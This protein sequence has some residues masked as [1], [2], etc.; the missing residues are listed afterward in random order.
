MEKEE[1]LEI[2]RQGT[3]KPLTVEELVR[4]LKIDDIPVFLQLIRELELAGEIILT[5]KQKYGLPERMGLLSGRLQGNV[6][7]FAFLL[8][9]TQGHP[10]VYIGQEELN[11][12]LH[13]DRVVVRL[14]PSG[15]RGMRPEGEVIRILARANQTVVGTFDKCKKYGFLIPDDKRLSIDIFIPNEGMA[16]AQHG[17]KVVVE[18]IRW[19]EGR[20][21]PEGKIIEILGQSDQPG[22]DVLAIVRKYGLPEVFPEEV[23]Q[24]AENLPKIVLPAEM[25]GR[26]DFRGVKTV[27]IDGADAKDLDDAI[28]IEALPGGGWR[29]M[30]HIAD[31]AY[32]VPEGT[33]ID[34]EAF[35]RGNSV[36]L[37][38]RV[39]PMLPPKLS[40]G[41]CS[42]NAGEDRL[43]MTAII[44]LDGGAKIVAHEVTPSVINVDQRMT[45][46][47]V[48]QILGNEDLGLVEQYRDFVPEF[49][50]MA[51]LAEKLFERRMKRGAIDFN[52]PEFKVILD[53]QGKPIE[54]KKHYRT[55]AESIIEEFMLLVNETIAEYMYWLEAPFIYRV[56][57]DPDLDNVAE[58]N[59]FLHNLGYH[60]KVTDGEVT[61]Q[62][63]QDVINKVLGEPEEKVVNTVVLR[64]M[65]HA[66]YSPDSLGHFGLAAQYYAH[67]TAPI[68]RYA[69]LVIHRIIRE[70]LIGEPTEKRII[71]LKRQMPAWAEQASIREKAA[72]EA[73]RESVDLKMVEYMKRHLGEVFSGTISGV[74]SFGLFVE[75]DNGVEGLVHIST[76]ADDY[77]IFQEKQLALLGQ[78]TR[79]SYRLGGQ[80][81]V[82]VVKVNVEER[83]IDFELKDDEPQTKPII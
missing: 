62:S 25:E 70:Y 57:E 2:M 34:E 76:I 81:T 8:P 39:I 49:K 78:H 65:R 80:V 48:R 59:D 22:V 28:S 72:E 67:F 64:S 77:Y 74:T 56:H 51:E 42:L 30:V 66:R 58:L 83:Q 10:D 16:D 7:G 45:Y 19:Q 47:G 63:F 35:T 82:L 37:V 55:I 14:S 4:E 53:D 43:A 73:E 29:L 23:I 26:R 18:I 11:G 21:S 17:D 1:L 13:N 32:Y 44:E 5:R 6:K 3:Y 33:P 52:F 38:D 68:R 46:E 61:P 27:T 40:N 24:E 54:I 75:L 20:R 71:A 79:K 15:G 69:D 12:A 31:V 9:S 60:V 36:Y 41:I 50:L